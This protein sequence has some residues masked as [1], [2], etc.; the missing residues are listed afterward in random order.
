MFD[1]TQL[2]RI[3]QQLDLTQT[4]FARQAGVSQSLIT[5]IESGKLDPKYSTVRRIEET[6]AR[7]ERGTQRTITEVMHHGIAAATMK[8]PLP[9]LIK[10]MRSL[11]ISQ[12]PVMDGTHVAGLIT[13]QDILEAIAKGNPIMNLRAQDIMQDAPPILP[14]NT[15][16][17]VAIRLLEHV[18]IVLV[19]GEKGIAGVVTRSD[20]LKVASW[21]QP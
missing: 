4:A 13:E 18:S 16:L 10:R 2:K 1:I 17:S 21:K 5:K 11:G 6:I 15:P 14:A 9:H 20:M 8:E 12:V 3:R 7:L 19:R